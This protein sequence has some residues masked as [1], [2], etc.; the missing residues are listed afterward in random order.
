MVFS[1]RTKAGKGEGQA[2]MRLKVTM[3]MR[4]ISPG[5]DYL[6]PKKL[7]GLGGKKNAR[8]KKPTDRSNREHNNG[9]IMEE[10]EEGRLA[11]RGGRPRQ[12][13][14]RREGNVTGL[15]LHM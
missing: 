5:P 9:I 15:K 8:E 1:G 3:N 11:G 13:A 4:H 6:S 12:T 2:G 7:A 14:L 10:R